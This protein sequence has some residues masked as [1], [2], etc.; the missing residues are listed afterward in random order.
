MLVLVLDQ[1]RKKRFFVVTGPPSARC[2]LLRTSLLLRLEA[3]ASCFVARFGSTCTSPG[4]FSFF[5]RIFPVLV[6]DSFILT[7]LSLVIPFMKC[8]WHRST[9]RLRSVFEVV[10]S[11]LS[12][13]L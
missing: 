13:F 7:Y 2:T 10:T 11:F 9:D 5:V 1:K 8:R 3:G 12:H 6:I 4:H